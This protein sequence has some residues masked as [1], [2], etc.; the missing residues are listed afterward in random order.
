MCVYVIVLDMRKICG[1][2]ELVEGLRGR[3]LGEEGR[4]EETGGWQG[5]WDGMGAFDSEWTLDSGGD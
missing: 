3:S 1:G 2:A 5:D 4:E